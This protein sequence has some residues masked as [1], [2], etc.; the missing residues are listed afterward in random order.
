M[1]ACAPSP[2]HGVKHGRA[3]CP[4]RPWPSSWW[5]SGGTRRPPGT[6]LTLPP[7]PAPVTQPLHPLSSPPT[8]EATVAARRPSSPHLLVADRLPNGPRSLA[9]SL[10]V[11]DV[12]PPRSSSPSTSAHALPRPV[13]ALGHASCP[14]RAR[15]AARSRAM[16]CSLRPL[17]LLPP[18]HALA[19]TCSGPHSTSTAATTHLAP[20]APLA[21][22][23]CIARRRCTRTAL[24]PATQ[25]PAVVR[26]AHARVRR[27]HGRWWLWAT[28]QRGRR[29][30]FY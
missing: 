20:A 24:A 22:A 9:A 11:N 23:A 30:C 21:A 25:A 26:R 28:G 8:P 1:C 5:P 19:S 14:S 29:P 7:P 10:L 3:R 12:E 15:T 18:A 2:V 17:L 6:Y 27:G 4:P 16:P 13:R